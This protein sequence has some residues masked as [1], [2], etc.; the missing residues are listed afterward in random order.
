MARPHTHTHKR[1]VSTRNDTR[2]NV[3][4]NVYSRR[5]TSNCRSLLRL[6]KQGSGVSVRE[7]EILRVC[8]G[9]GFSDARKMRVF[10]RESS[11]RM[12]YCCCLRELA[13]AF[14][15]LPEP[16]L[17][18]DKK[19][20]RGRG[21][22]TR[23]QYHH[24]R[25]VRLRNATRRSGSSLSSERDETLGE[26]DSPRKKTRTLARDAFLAQRDGRKLRTESSASAR[27]THT[28]R[29]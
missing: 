11:R 2:Y 22:K 26:D 27:H 23:T 8:V 21:R 9:P 17:L 7:R 25:H 10:P 16:T 20:M 29:E 15:R 3:H 5:T 4:I 24:R 28:H 1:P 18:R 19:E 12:E 6:G 14:S 13:S